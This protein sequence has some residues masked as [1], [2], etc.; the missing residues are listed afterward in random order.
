MASKKSNNT[1]LVTALFSN[2]EG[3]PIFGQNRTRSERYL[4]SLASIARTGEKIVCYLEEQYIEEYRDFWNTYGREKGYY[5]I[6][7]FTNIEFVYITLDQFRHS[8]RMFDLK[9][10]YSTNDDYIMFHEIDWIK[11]Q[12]LEQ[13][14][15]DQHDYFYWIDCGLSHAGLFPCAASEN[16]NQEG[17]ADFRHY[18]SNWPMYDFGRI[19]NPNL[20]PK[21]NNFVGNKLLG[22]CTGL[23]FWN[24]QALHDLLIKTKYHPNSTDEMYYAG[25]TSRHNIGGIFGGHKDHINHLITEFNTIGQLSLDNEIIPNH[26]V[27]MGAIKWHNP[28]LFEEYFFDTWYHEDTWMT[29]G[30]L[31]TEPEW[32]ANGQQVKR[33]A[34]EKIQFYGF[35]KQI[36]LVS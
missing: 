8:Q 26:E 3:F 6:D 1:K 12:L 30:G 17:L 34:K 4:H 5:D 28:E 13:E 14:I 22:L 18:S 21:I 24:T 31:M 29:Q 2:H 11:L 10:K 15:D 25:F 36:G 19:F 9:Q 33:E 27:I 16:P 20:F 35:F 32:I 23:V 7:D